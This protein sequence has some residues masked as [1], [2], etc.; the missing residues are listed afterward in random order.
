MEPRPIKNVRGLGSPATP[1]SGT[2]V[3]PQQS[4]RSRTSSLG[5]RSASIT[6]VSIP[7]DNLSLASDDT[8]ELCNPDLLHDGYSSSGRAT[9]DVARQGDDFIS[10][11]SQTTTYSD[12]PK[13]QLDGV[14]G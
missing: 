2:F 8:D 9:E 6:E 14:N 1:M 3:F 4:V 10:P 12:I 7:L 11:R 5:R 13:L